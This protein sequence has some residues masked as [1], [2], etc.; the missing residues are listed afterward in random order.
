M[1]QGSVALFNSG[2][3]YQSQTFS[4]TFYKH[5]FYPYYCGFHQ[6]MTGWVNVTG[7]DVQP[8]SPP[9]TTSSV[10]YTPYIIGGII[11]AIVIVSAALF[12]RH[13]TRKS[14]A[15]SPSKQS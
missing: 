5:G 13:R 12:L 11:G 7:S 15:T 8:P 3:L 6:Y 2:T 14:E 4:Y 10:D 9:S 1:T